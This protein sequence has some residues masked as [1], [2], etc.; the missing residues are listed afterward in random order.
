MSAPTRAPHYW[1]Y[2]TSEDGYPP[3]EGGPWCID[4]IVAEAET[5]QDWMVEGQDLPITVRPIA[6]YEK[7]G[8]GKIG[9]RAR[10]IEG[11]ITLSMDPSG[12][13]LA[14]AHVG[15]REVFRGYIDRPWEE[16]EIWPAGATPRRDEEGP[17]RMGKKR[18]W[19][20]LSPEAWP[21][22]RSITNGLNALIVEIAK[23]KGAR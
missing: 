12:W 3:A 14:L 10:G 18:S 16:Y 11:E 9:F 15:G 8:A 7:T 23:N 5:F 1:D 20:A 2:G 21:Q 19:M 17:G 22:L 13:I 6:R 4:G